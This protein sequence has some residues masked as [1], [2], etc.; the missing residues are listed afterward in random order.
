QLERLLGTH[1]QPLTLTFGQQAYTLERADLLKLLSLSG[2]TK[3]GQPAVVNVDEAPLKAW[4]AKMARDINQPVQDARFRFK[5][6]NLQ[7]RRVARHQTQQRG[8]V[9]GPVGGRAAGARRV[10]RR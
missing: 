10:A 8:P 4:A 3:P 7:G 1:A 2:G 6:G 5:G 9:R